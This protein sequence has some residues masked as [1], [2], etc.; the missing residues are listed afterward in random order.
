[1][2]THYNYALNPKRT[3]LPACQL[4]A[5]GKA[6]DFSRYAV[7]TDK[8]RVTCRTCR[9]ALGMDQPSTEAERFKKAERSAF[10]KLG[11]R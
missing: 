5:L 4:G 3:R 1:M 6:K 8:A 11:A 10:S 2:T 7:T 9:K